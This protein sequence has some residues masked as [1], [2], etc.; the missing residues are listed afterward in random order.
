[1]GMSF[2][3]RAIFILNV[4][5]LRSAIMSMSFLRTLMLIFTCQ[6]FSYF[7]VITAQGV[8]LLQL[9]VRLL[10]L[11]RLLGPV[12]RSYDPRGINTFVSCFVSIR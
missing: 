1:M 12:A 6:Q 5:F 7:W 4:I 11:F 3:R 10:R 9:Q 2:L 8:Q